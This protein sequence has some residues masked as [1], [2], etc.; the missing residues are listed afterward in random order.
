MSFT[1]H[2]FQEGQVLTAEAMN[3]IEAAI[4]GNEERIGDLESQSAAADL[5]ITSHA[6]R[7]NEHDS[8]IKELQD[9][10][11]E[12][13]EK[14]EGKLDNTFEGEG[15]KFLYIDAE[16]DVAPKTIASLH[17][18]VGEIGTPENDVDY[19]VQDNNKYIHYRGINGNLE[20]IGSAAEGK[21]YYSTY[22]RLYAGEIIPGV[23]AG[24]EDYVFRLWEISAE[25]YVENVMPGDAGSKWTMISQSIIGADI[26]RSIV[27][28]VLT[29]DVNIKNIL[30]SDLE[31]GTRVYLKFKVNS[32]N[33]EGTKNY[34]INYTVTHNSAPAPFRTATLAA[35]QEDHEISIDVTNM[36]ATGNNLFQISFV[37]SLGTKDYL[38]HSINCIEFSALARFN[39]KQIYLVNQ[40]NVTLEYTVKGSNLT[41]K[42]YFKIYDESNNEVKSQDYTTQ[43]NEK[44]YTFN[45]PTNLS[46]GRYL[47]KCWSEATVN[48]QKIST[49]PVFF[50][51]VLV[52]NGN[53]TPIIG[54][55]H[56]GET[57]EIE[58]YNTVNLD[59]FVYNNNQQQPTI[60]T[61]VV[62]SQTVIS[63]SE[64][65]Q[66]DS[67]V[68]KFTYKFNELGD[69]TITIYTTDEEGKDI[70]SVSVNIKVKELIIS[71]QRPA[72]NSVVIDFDATLSKPFERE[73]VEGYYRLKVGEE[74]KL[75]LP[76]GKKEVKPIYLNTN[77]DF[78]WINGGY[79]TDEDGVS[80]FLIKAGDTLTINHA[81]FDGFYDSEQGEKKRIG[82]NGKSIKLVYKVQNSTNSETPF[83]VAYTE[84]DVTIKEGDEEVTKKQRSGLKMFPQ[85]AYY[86]QGLEGTENSSLHLP[87][88]EEDVIDFCLTLSK[89]PTPD[90]DDTQDFLRTSIVYG[91]EDGV[92]TKPLV[93][94]AGSLYNDLKSEEFFTIGSEHSDVIIYRLK[95]YNLGL[96][97]EQVLAEFI[98]DAKDGNTIKERDVRNTLPD[99]CNFEGITI[100]S[101]NFQDVFGALSDKYP[102]LRFILIKTDKPFTTSKD[103]KVDETTVY[104]WFKGGRAVE[105]NWIAI[106]AI[107]S[108]QGTSS[109]NY[110]AA[111]RNLDINL[112]GARITSMYG[113]EELTEIS[114][115]PTSIPNKYF[116]I[117]VNVASSENANNALLQKRYNEY[118]PYTRPFVDSQ[119]IEGTD[120]SGKPITIIPKDTMEFHNCVVFIWE[121]GNN[122]EG[123]TSEQ[124][125]IYDNNRKAWRYEKNTNINFYAL[126]NIGDSKKTD[127][128]RLTDPN[129]PFEFIVE[130]MDI[131]LPLC[132]F[133]LAKEFK[134]YQGDHQLAE[135][136]LTNDQ[137]NEKNGSSYGWRYIYDEGTDVNGDKYKK[138][139]TPISSL[140][141]HWQ[142]QAKDI[143]G[144]D[145]IGQETIADVCKKLWV[146]FYNTVVATKNPINS[147]QSA[148][149]KY[150][151]EYSNGE[152]EEYSNLVDLRIGTTPQNWKEL[153]E[154]KVVLDSVIYYSL[155][156][157][158]YTMVDNRAKNSFWH[159]GKTD[160]G[161]RKWDLC[162]DY[163]ND[164]ALGIDNRGELNYRYGYEDTDLEDEGISAERKPV[165]REHDSTFFCRLVANYN[166]AEDDDKFSEVYDKVK[167]QHSE[168]WKSSSLI[169]QF[170]NWQAQ[171]PERFWKIDSRKKYIN[172]YNKVDGDIVT[173]QFLTEMACGRKKYQRRQFERNQYNYMGIKYRDND[174]PNIYLRAASGNLEN[175]LEILYQGHGYIG[176]STKE[177]DIARLTRIP[178]EDGEPCPVTIAGDMFKIWG[179]PW[180]TAI[181]KLG[182][183]KNLGAA[184]LGKASKIS[185][186]DV[187]GSDT[188]DKL[189]LTENGPIQEINFSNTSSLTGFTTIPYG[190]EY[191]ENL[192]GK[193]GFETLP[194]LK[195]V[196]AAGSG[197]QSFVFNNGTVIEELT[198]SN[199]ATALSL[200]K[201]EKLE[202][203]NYRNATNLNTLKVFEG[204]LNPE[205]DLQN[206][207][208][209]SYVK[210]D[211][212]KNITTKEMIMY[213]RSNSKSLRNVELY[214]ID[215][216]LTNTSD[217]LSEESDYNLIEYLYN[218]EDNS[219]NKSVKLSGK[220]YFN[221][222]DSISL[223]KYE[224]RWPD[225]DF[226][227][228]AANYITKYEVYFY[229][230]GFQVDYLTVEE[231]GMIGKPS[232]E[233][234]KDQ[235]NEF[236]YKF[237]HWYDEKDKTQ[238]NAF[239]KGEIQV[240]SNMNFHA[241]FKE[242]RQTYDVIF[243][244][245]V[246]DTD[247]LGEATTVEYGGAVDDDY[248][249]DME[250]KAK[251]QQV[252]GADRCRL[253]SGWDKTPYKITGEIKQNKKTPVIIN[254]LWDT[255]NSVSNK[256]S[257]DL[258]AAELKWLIENGRIDLTDM[259]DDEIG[260]P[261][262]V[263]SKI[264]IPMGFRMPNNEYFGKA[265]VSLFKDE[266][267]LS[268]GEDIVVSDLNVNLLENLNRDWTLLVDAST[269]N[270]QKGVVFSCVD[271]NGRGL[272]IRESSN[273]NSVCGYIVEWFGMTQTFSIGQ[274][275]T[276]ATEGTYRNVFVL[277]HRKE[278]PN[279]LR[280]HSGNHLTTK[281]NVSEI[282]SSG[283]DS[284]NTRFI[285]GGSRNS[286]GQLSNL[287]KVEMHQCMLWEDFLL[288]EK[289]IELLTNWP[290]KDQYWAV[291]FGGTYEYQDASGE[292]R[293]TYL[294]LIALDSI[295]RIPFFSHGGELS[296][297]MTP[298]DGQLY[299]FA[300]NVKI[301]EGGVVE[302]LDPNSGSGNVK[303]YVTELLNSRFYNAV[304]KNW[305]AI[306]AKP[307]IPCSAIAIQNEGEFK[308]LS[309][310]KPEL[311]VWIPSVPEFTGTGSSEGGN[312][313]AA[314]GSNYWKVLQ[315]RIRVEESPYGYV[316]GRVPFNGPTD[317]K[318]T[319]TVI[320]G[321]IWFKDKYAFNGKVASGDHAEWSHNFGEGDAFHLTR[322]WF[323]SRTILESKQTANMIQPYHIINLDGVGYD[324]SFDLGII[325]PCIS[326]K[327]TGR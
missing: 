75:V 301:G 21:F 210:D 14:C 153:I 275:R 10:T 282:T 227:Y 80:Y 152:T 314:D 74:R 133:P 112:E 111:A 222:I 99:G 86:Y 203:L 273:H 245:E 33:P 294:D 92:S 138:G 29:E 35:Q 228:N 297:I 173:T 259:T 244:A 78:D 300:P 186:L 225:V 41:K 288:S 280:V 24:Q 180:I 77:P 226:S 169:S 115:T 5:S 197:I 146:D 216:R 144:L 200:P 88:S 183:L 148:E 285:M 6:T 185:N 281:Q 207:D 31:E 51:M 215:W 231:G 295:G 102:D 242:T 72:E 130:I 319:E 159:Y 165:F 302:S 106:N 255:A 1:K 192:S 296:S 122:D 116:N 268:Y 91:Y 224:N 118:N 277:Q 265:P 151:V 261:I 250:Q 66:L 101:G 30:K 291:V 221:V 306:M 175:E 64:P 238:A 269:V 299:T 182:K 105:D 170:D 149:D 18:N 315:N 132:D 84:E 7:L 145:E 49:P 48:Y 195:K 220:I 206:L 312:W 202:K 249:A 324:S 79:K 184:A 168:A 55:A 103:D 181:N 194:N 11:S 251:D 107:H 109:N 37:D 36:I 157:T 58:Q 42:T 318:T 292:K 284:I 304:P 15:G 59:Y 81:L 110:G 100:H 172:S 141:P 158:R 247:P 27:S 65:E 38:S 321:D 154:E 201:A 93:L 82:I 320:E 96:D 161:V 9:V 56:R 39:D 190:N 214:G 276:N 217:E 257:T 147:I 134:E 121:T 235:T 3:E 34:S 61:E 171:F 307:F 325:I 162:F 293:P 104:H 114:L 246:G 240:W 310:L 129:D 44:K 253:F 322:R 230:D 160:S 223:K 57:I 278:F 90:G 126:G 263:G 317:P 205:I 204:A 164:T 286:L 193:N 4:E 119:K 50:D 236:T 8:E 26:E 155:F 98:L 198:L 87:Y 95:V 219:G 22:G 256:S 32:S 108:G 279:V 266:K 135:D 283:A 73:E 16:G 229:K 67:M 85:Q 150:V 272:I 123:A 113:G 128:S 120:D 196:E 71:T 63:S 69:Y 248:L 211:N 136:W 298:I 60:R 174:M 262:V 308:P 94:D 143:L 176:A 289:D 271:N 156:T 124:Y 40:D 53:A 213:Y 264:K 179:T 2:N 12:L 83:F 270:V 188:L 243:Y 139:K 47:I 258:S 137:M 326:I 62:K 70:G 237:S 45:I 163:D 254:G 316:K 274:N 187:S 13:E 209:I 68:G 191:D 97:D 117:K 267:K 76:S 218:L 232:E 212:D 234:T 19:Y 241:K 177:I 305:Q 25:D 189:Q 178:L 20:L 17:Y 199:V 52:E 303:P 23:Q 167:V 208:S 233:P 54:C 127:K 46:H 309:L 260:S 327:N 252:I 287:C 140:E 131:D 290:Q 43:D 125:P 239:A 89:E 166:N 142:K 311:H 28:S 313:G 323:T